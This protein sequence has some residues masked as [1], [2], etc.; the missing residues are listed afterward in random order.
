[1]STRTS[2]SSAAAVRNAPPSCRGSRTDGA[3][4]RR[5]L[6]SVRTPRRSASPPAA[7]RRGTPR[8]GST[9]RPVLG[10]PRSFTRRAPRSS[11][12]RFIQLVR[13]RGAAREQRSRILRVEEPPLHLE[14][15][16]RSSRAPAPVHSRLD[17]LERSAVPRSSSARVGV[18]LQRKKLAPANSSVKQEPEWAAVISSTGVWLPFPTSAPRA[19]SPHLHGA[20]AGRVPPLFA[21][22]TADRRG[23]GDEGK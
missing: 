23:A 18:A 16:P 4:A 8:P 9:A 20:R 3:R 7:P 19:G 13:A 22:L 21:A 10:G 1:M 12:R 2:G 15:A 14:P 17:R 5:A 6:R 11:T